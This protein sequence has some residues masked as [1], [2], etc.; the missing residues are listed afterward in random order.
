MF[1][2]QTDS[3]NI[4][5]VLRCAW[6]QKVTS[7]HAWPAADKSEF[8]TKHTFPAMV[9]R[10]IYKLSQMRV[11]CTQNDLLHRGVTCCKQTNAELAIVYTYTSDHVYEYIHSLCFSGYIDRYTWNIN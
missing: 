9:V 6:A 3:L 2:K 11:V 1:E 5:I 7:R 10:R 8:L 4:N